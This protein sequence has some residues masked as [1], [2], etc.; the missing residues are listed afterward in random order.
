M[1]THKPL[2]KDADG[3]DVDEH[4][5]RSMI[6]SLMYLTSS[7]PDNMFV[8]F[9]WNAVTSEVLNKGSTTNGLLTTTSLKLMQLAIKLTTAGNVMVV[10]VVF[11]EKPTESEGFEEIV[12]FLN[13][14]PIKYVLTVNPTVYCSC[15]KQFW[16]TVKAK[17]VN[18]EVQLQAL[19]DKKKVI[20]IEST[21]RRDLQL[22]DAEGTE[23]LPTATIFEELTRMG[24]KQKKDTEVSQPSGPTKPMTDETENVE[25]VPTASNDPLL[26]GEDRLTLTKLMD[27]CTNLQ[28]KVLDLEKAKTAQDSEIANLKK[29]VKKLERRNNID[30]DEGVTLV[31]K[32]EGRNDEEMFDT[33]ILDGEEVFTKQ[34]VVEKE[35][36]TADPVTTAGEVVTTA[37]VEVT[38]VSAITTTVDELTLAQTLIEIKAAKPK[39]RGVMIQEPSETTTTTTTPAASKPSQD[40]GK[41]KMTESEKPLK[42]KD[43]IMYDQ[44]VALN[45]QAQLQAELEEEERLAR[46]KEEEANI[47]LIESWDNTQAMMDADRLLA[48][49]LQAREQEELTDEEKARLFVELLEKRKKHFAALRAQEKRNKPPTK[50]QKKSTMST[51]LKHMAGYKQSQLKNKSFAEIQKLFDKAM[52][53]VNMF[54]DMDTELVRESSKK[55]EAEMAQESSSKRAGDE[56]EQEKA[57]KQKIDDDQEEAKMKELIE[58]VSDEEGVAIDAIPLSTKPPSIVDYKIIKEGNISIYQIIRADG[59]SK[60]YSAIIHMLRNFDRE[61]LETL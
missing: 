4:L 15:I 37:S 56:L 39:V 57:K 53:R 24:R 2:L 42:K 18:E 6:E 34:D 7:R 51:Y 46:Q 8:V 61:D 25:N 31:N 26:S 11:L 50:A 49:R 36:S 16:D 30:A 1:E 35:V 48:E 41:A 45:L 27:L 19:V 13:A 33:G 40:K 43:Q 5:Y 14:N 21:I 47:A 52:T 32:T 12:N 10:E 60:R 38:T 3:E 22:E 17:T 55:D 20:I 58:V 59:S 28:K 9:L 23:C 29:R 44:E 54:V